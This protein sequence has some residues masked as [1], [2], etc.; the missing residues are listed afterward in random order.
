MLDGDNVRH[1]LSK[2]L[3]FAPADR[4]ENNRR[5]AEVA[6]ILT[7]AGLI[8]VAAFVSPFSADR[9]T[10]KALFPEGGFVE[11]FVDVPA[12]LAAE[13]DTKGLY[14]KARGGELE[15]LTG[16]GSVY[17]A[18]ESPDVH[19]DMSALDAEQAADRVFAALEERG[20]L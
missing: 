20:L 6:K 3:G 13:R 16:I 14:A 15:N 19:L 4:A 11:V 18:P 17:E 7:D 10:T 12:E 8:V 2:D 5:A 1:G 9:E